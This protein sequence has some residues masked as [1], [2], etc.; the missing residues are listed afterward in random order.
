MRRTLLLLALTF[1]LGT[2]CAAQAADGAL[3][4]D[5]ETTF[6]VPMRNQM[7]AKHLWPELVGQPAEAAKAALVQE[8]P[9]N[10]LVLLV[11]ENSMMTMDFRTNRVRIIYSKATGLVVSPPR[12]G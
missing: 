7:P 8:L 1:A 10:S 5:A 12:I 9:A 2:A 6:T 11:P 4:F 3:D